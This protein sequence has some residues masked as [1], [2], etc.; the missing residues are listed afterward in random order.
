MC[1]LMKQVGNMYTNETSFCLFTNTMRSLD[2]QKS[3]KVRL[4]CV[5]IFY[6]CALLNY[7]L[8]VYQFCIHL[9]TNWFLY[10]FIYLLIDDLMFRITIIN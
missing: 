6:G 10:S 2:L 8:F 3:C 9:F 7:D 1:I 5:F 4:V